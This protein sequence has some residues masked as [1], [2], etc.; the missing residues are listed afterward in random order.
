MQKSVNII[1]HQN[2]HFIWKEIYNISQWRNVHK[3]IC[4]E[5]GQWKVKGIN[6]REAVRWEGRK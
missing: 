1:R 5:L 6:E 2:K 3:N 4:W